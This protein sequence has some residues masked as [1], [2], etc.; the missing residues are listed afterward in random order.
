MEH[1]LFEKPVRIFVGLNFPGEIETVAQAFAFL[2]DWPTG[3]RGPAH[4]LALNTCRGAIERTVEAKTA[5]KAFESFARVARI[6]APEVS[7]VVAA[8]AMQAA[9]ARTPP[10]ARRR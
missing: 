8:E 4:T 10:G 1:N 7:D 5:R 2:N 6:L 9:A 3:R